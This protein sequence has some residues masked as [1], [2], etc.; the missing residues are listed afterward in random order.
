MS[1]HLADHAPA[2]GVLNASRM[3]YLSGAIDGPA[4][5]DVSMEGVI[6]RVGSA[7]DFDIDGHP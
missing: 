1:S 7:T 4:G 2:D 6:T 5:V 3:I